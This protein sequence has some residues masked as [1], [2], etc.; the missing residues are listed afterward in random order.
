MERVVSIEGGFAEV[1]A[2]A[3]LLSYYTSL[4]K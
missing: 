1:G 2:G 3:W 4:L